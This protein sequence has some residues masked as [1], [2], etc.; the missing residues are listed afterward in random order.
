MSAPEAKSDYPPMNQTQS[1]YNPIS[2]QQYPMQPLQNLDGERQGVQK[3]YGGQVQKSPEEY[4]RV[5][6]GKVEKH[7]YDDEEEN[8]GPFP[9]GV[10]EKHFNVSKSWLHRSYSLQSS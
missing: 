4:I 5:E 8:P 6:D 2:Y 7:E 3:Q 9:G 10:P 1:P